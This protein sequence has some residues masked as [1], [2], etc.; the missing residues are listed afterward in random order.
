MTSLELHEHLTPEQHE[1]WINLP[2]HKYDAALEQVRF[3]IENGVPIIAAI[4]NV[5]KY[6]GKFNLD[7]VPF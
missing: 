7:D 1:R 4:V 2:E 3:L 5:D 6:V